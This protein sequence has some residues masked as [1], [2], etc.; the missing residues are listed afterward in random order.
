MLILLIAFLIL[1]G[2]GLLNPG[3]FM[4]TKKLV[5]KIDFHTALMKVM[6]SFLLFA[7][8][9]NIDLNILKKEILAILTFSTIGVVISTFVVAILFYF[10]SAFGIEINFIYCLL[11]GALISLTEPITVLGI[12][13]TAKIPPTLETKVSGESLFNDRVAVVVFL[14]IFEVIV[15]DVQNVSAG[16]VAWLF[17]KEAGGGM[18][19]G[20]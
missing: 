8:A 7:G 15:S 1:I 6:L 4:Q 10:A 16:R 20:F 19:F 5:S 14:T 9:I 13:K 17:I 18:V 11:F 3:F 2:I 12:L